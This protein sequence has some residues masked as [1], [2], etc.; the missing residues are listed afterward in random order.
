MAL[1]NI[2]NTIS[3]VALRRIVTP[4]SFPIPESRNRLGSKGIVVL[5]PGV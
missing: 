2:Q 1:A 4:E 3:K 5:A